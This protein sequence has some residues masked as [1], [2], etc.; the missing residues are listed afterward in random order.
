MEE[1]VRL[2][3]CHNV[4]VNIS[5]MGQQEGHLLLLLLLLLELLLAALPPKSLTKGGRLSIERRWL[6]PFVFSE[7][8]VPREGK[9]G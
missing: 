7:V 1:R 4:G 3:R 6:R 8:P 2:K 9:G 5:A